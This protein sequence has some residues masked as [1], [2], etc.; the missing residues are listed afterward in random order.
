MPY[1]YGGGDIIYAVDI[2]AIYEASVDRPACILQQ[3]VSQSIPDNTT[4]AITFTTETLDTH[5]FHSTSSNTTRIT[6]TVAGWYR[7]HGV[8]WAPSLGT[9]ATVVAGI[10]KNGTTQTSPERHATPPT[11]GSFTDTVGGTYSANGT[12]D[13]F[14]LTMLQDNTANSAQNTLVSGSN[15]CYFECVFERGL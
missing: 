7:F 10:S 5:G 12:T 13:Y 1:P 6:P 4:T 11:S 8:V 2:N 14:E 3:T 9:Y 15:A